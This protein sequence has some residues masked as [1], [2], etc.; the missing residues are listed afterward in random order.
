MGMEGVTG[1]VPF[2]A[3]TVSGWSVEVGI[4]GSSWSIP[5]T[6]LRRQVDVSPALRRQFASL[7]NDYQTQSAHGTACASLHNTRGRLA[8]FLLLMSDRANSASIV[9]TQSDLSFAL[10][11]QRTTINA[12]ADAL[13]SLGAIRYRRG[14]IEIVNRELL[15]SQACE[16]HAMQQEML[17][18]DQSGSAKS[19]ERPALSM[20]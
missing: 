12:E 3:D 6:A 18:R 10:G 14:R 8:H 5:A 17:G 19:V 9:M 11:C 16:C 13:R 15:V 2:M 1:L 20:A 7:V 4:S